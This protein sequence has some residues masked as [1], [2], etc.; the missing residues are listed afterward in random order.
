V[1]RRKQPPPVGRRHPGYYP[2][3]DVLSQQAFWDEATRR[4]ILDRVYNLPPLRF[5]SAEEA[6]LMQAIAD[7]L[8]PQDDREPEVRVPIVPRIDEKL[9][10]HR[11]PGYRYEDMPPQAEAMRLGLQGIEAI[12]K[13]LF[14]RDFPDLDQTQQDEVLL[15]LHGGQPPAGEAIWRQVP[16]VH[17]WVQI[18]NDCI[19][20]YYSH[21]FAWD[22]IG[23]GGPAFPR[24][25]FRLSGGQPEPWEVDEQRYDWAPPG[26]SRSAEHRPIGHGSL[27]YVPGQAGT[28]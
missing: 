13:H 5:F 6:R 23:F 27:R 11:I 15:A 12:A 7:R 25:Y 19:E 16:P 9:F 2:G 1:G 8:I 26:G 24:G 28:H 17:F 21:P 22:E 20:A 3:Y 18:L 14:G 4:V 10:E